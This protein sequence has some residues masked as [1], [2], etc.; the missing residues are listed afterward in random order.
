MNALESQE[1]PKEDACKLHYRITEIGVFVCLFVLL[2]K[3][4]IVKPY[5]HI[6][7]GRKK[8]G[9]KWIPGT[10]TEPCD[11]ANKNLGVFI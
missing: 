2:F 5:P 7:L 10:P 1:L 9:V 8:P 3:Y 4:H 6:F 11:V